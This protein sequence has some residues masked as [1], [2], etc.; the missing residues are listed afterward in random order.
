MFGWLVG[1]FDEIEF[2]VCAGGQGQGLVKGGR[3]EKVGDALKERSAIDV[4]PIVVP[5]FNKALAKVHL[6]VQVLLLELQQ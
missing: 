6:I 3:L 1:L 2:V 4:Y 5:L